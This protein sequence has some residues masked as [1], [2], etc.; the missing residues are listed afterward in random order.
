MRRRPPLTLVAFMAMVGVPLV[1]ALVGSGPDPI[2]LVAVAV[3]GGLLVGLYLRLRIAWI[4][5]M[6]LTTGNLLAG[7]LREVPWWSVAILGLEVALL[8][9]PPTRRYVFGA[10][11]EAWPRSP[12]ARRPLTVGALLFAGLTSAGVLAL[13]F[14][15]PDPVSGDL[16]LVRSQRSGFR[17]LFVGNSLTER[18]SMTRMVRE[19]GKGNR[20]GPA[21]FA[22]QYARGG[23]T[24][25]DA[26]DDSRL[27][28]LL[29]GEPWDYV[30]LQE[31]SRIASKPDERDE[32]MLP[33]AKELKS[34]AR[35]DRRLQTF[36]FLSWGYRDGDGDDDSYAAMQSRLDR[37]YYKVASSIHAFIAPVGLA[38]R[39]ALAGRPGVDLWS[40][41]GL[42]PSRAGSY[43]TACVFYELFTHRDVTRS[44]YTADLDPAEARRLQQIATGAVHRFYP[45]IPAS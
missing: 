38:W 2:V 13:M 28:R 43:L 30:V 1:G 10:Q 40:D 19:L 11:R 16:D 33:A 31:H 39:A 18:N 36:L 25:E 6:V 32:H 22:V 42:H 8:V 17:V 29:E 37:N 27:T 21:I 26:L 35:G 4:L 45:S 15:P 9:A 7:L 24:L 14:F 23:S 12:R 20:G 5:G 3:F 41:D 34:M 44:H